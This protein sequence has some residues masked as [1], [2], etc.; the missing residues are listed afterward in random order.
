MVCLGSRLTWDFG[1]QRH[2][3]RRAH[4]CGAYRQP[5]GLPIGSDPLTW[6]MVR[7]ELDSA[8]PVQLSIQSGLQFAAMATS[9]DATRKR[10]GRPGR[11]VA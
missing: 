7:Q 5:G 3:S 10:R 1:D 2:R 6:C 11:T 4:G 8:V 9:S